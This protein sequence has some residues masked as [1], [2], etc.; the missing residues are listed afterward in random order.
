M[1]VTVHE[2]FCAVIS[3]SPLG[4]FMRSHAKMV[5]SLPYA[6]PEIV[7]TRVTMVVMWFLKAAREMG[8]VYASSGSD[9]FRPH[10]AYCRE[11]GGLVRGQL[12]GLLGGL[13]GGRLGGRL[14][15]G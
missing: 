6:I 4:S 3:Q 5:G 13:S 11:T 12:G 1:V 2:A 7:F 8:L 10:S 15:V 14:G 9:P